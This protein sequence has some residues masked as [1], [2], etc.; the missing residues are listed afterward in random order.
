MIWGRLRGTAHAGKPNN[1]EARI[2]ALQLRPLQLRIAGKIARGP[3][4]KPE[5]GLAEQAIIEGEEI[6]IQP[7]KS[8]SFKSFC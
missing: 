2:V 4:E 8:N 3:Q 6:V 1:S 5:E 7:A